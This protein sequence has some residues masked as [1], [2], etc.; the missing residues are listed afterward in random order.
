[1]RLSPNPDQTMRTGIEDITDERTRQIF[2]KGFTTDHDKLYSEGQLL[3]AAAS[4]QLQAQFGG[5][6]K[7]PP[8]LWPW[9][10]AE[11]HP[12]PLPTRNLAKAG[13]L[14]AAE[15]DRLKNANKKKYEK[16][17]KENHRH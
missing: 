4:Y 15:I 7:Y 6:E 16:I 1:M 14:V 9:D 2:L 11:W 10:A 3:K 5:F 8:N 13:A 17:E 12:S